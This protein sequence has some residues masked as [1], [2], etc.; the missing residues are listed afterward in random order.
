M[1]SPYSGSGTSAVDPTGDYRLDALI[2]GEKWGG[3]A[4]TGVELTY[5]FP[6]AG[7]AWADGYGVGEPGGPNS[8]GL[9][10]NE[11]AWYRFALQ[12]WAEVADVR[13]TEVADTPSDVGDLPRRLLHPV[14]VGLCLGLLPRPVAGGRRRLAQHQLRLDARHRPLQLPDAG[15]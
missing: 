10:A 3:G 14:A 13:F 6:A 7:S 5:S 12:T 8:R 4:G 1:V 9:N 11:Q 15:P 2:A